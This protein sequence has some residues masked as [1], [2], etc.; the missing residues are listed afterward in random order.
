MTRTHVHARARA[1]WRRERWWER[2]WLRPKGGG[3]KIVAS[4]SG[5]HILQHLSAR[6]VCRE[7]LLG[8]ITPPVSPSVSLTLSLLFASAAKWSVS[9]KAGAFKWR[10]VSLG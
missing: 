5:S 9:F 1:I 4:E 3:S 2:A 10:L 8:N 7:L 6:S